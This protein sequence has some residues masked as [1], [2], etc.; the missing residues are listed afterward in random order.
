MRE[1]VR[2]SNSN[3]EYNNYENVWVNKFYSKYMSR[4]RTIFLIQDYKQQYQKPEKTPTRQPLI[5][6]KYNTKQTKDPRKTAAQPINK[7]L[8]AEN[9]NY[10]LDRI[11]IS[12]YIFDTFTKNLL[13]MNVYFSIPA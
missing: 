10:S 1:G 9:N 7:T 3:N 4:V 6:N 11:K 12:V 13:L 8:V 5:D 2:F